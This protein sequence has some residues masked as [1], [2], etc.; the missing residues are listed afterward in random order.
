MVLYYYKTLE[1]PI[2]NIFKKNTNFNFL[3][4]LEIHKPN[5]H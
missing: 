5:K 1:N 2:N 3:I 4:Q